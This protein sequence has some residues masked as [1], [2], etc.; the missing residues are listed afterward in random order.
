MVRIN[1][2]TGLVRVIL[3]FS[4]SNIVGLLSIEFFPYD[5]LR[6]MTIKTPGRPKRRTN[7]PMIFLNTALFIRITLYDE[8]ITV[9]VLSEPFLPL[10]NPLR[11]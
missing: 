11:Y 4:R 8:M 2:L 10:P 7:F 6:S 3:G 1:V 5:R 9:P